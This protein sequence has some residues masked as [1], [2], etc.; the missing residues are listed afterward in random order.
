MITKE[1]L[2]TVVLVLGVL[3]P[4][5]GAFGGEPQQAVSSK[6][7]TEQEGLRYEVIA[8]KGNVRIG[9]L[10]LD[11]K[12]NEGWSKAQVGDLLGA[13]LQV[14]VPLRGAIKLTA[15]PAEPP[16]VIM[17]EQVTLVA[18]T[19][20]GLAD[21]KAKSRIKLAYGA[22]RAG[23]AEG[24]TRSDME[25]ESPV[26]T[27]SK[28]GTDIFR[29]E[30]HNGHF[31]MSLSEEGRGLIQ[32]IQTRAAQLGALDRTRSRFLTPGQWISQQMLRA[33]DSVQFDRNVNVTDNFGLQ[34]LDQLFTMLNDRGGLAFLLPA[35][36]NPANILDSPTQT[37]M[38]GGRPLF[39]QAQTT[40]NQL[41]QSLF[42]G[43]VPK[44]THG[45]DFG[46]GQG[47]VPGVFGASSKAIA[48]K[49]NLSQLQQRTR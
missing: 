12:S 27:L 48:T 46:I 42:Q 4:A 33:I 36:N 45:G 9:P 26:A 13:G 30:C 49:H 23:V 1:R 18:V 38:I 3:V 40:Q 15:R 29:F 31:M 7:T 39:D 19:E 28:R 21:N 14:H 37:G 20:L 35:G 8:V 2:A 43:I 17:I 6:P 25:I 47:R 32:A 44:P 5:A 16:T 24:A 10:G 41:L 22:I 34:G 11:P